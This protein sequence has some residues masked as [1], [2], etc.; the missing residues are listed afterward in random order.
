V[1]CVIDVAEDIDLKQLGAAYER[2]AC[3]K[4]LKKKPAPKV[5]GVPHTTVTLG[6]I[7]ARDTSVPLETLG[8]ELD[9]LNRQHPDREW[10]DMVVVLSKGTINYGVHFPRRARDW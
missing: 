10:T 3:A 7:F 9:R 6:I 4:T 5:P 1:G 2:I 8:E